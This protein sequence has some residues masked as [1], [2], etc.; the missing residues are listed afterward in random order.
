ME[1]L[2]GLCEFHVNLVNSASLRD[3]LFFET[4]KGAKC[5]ENGSA[6]ALLFRVFSRIS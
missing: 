3:G 4:T 6:A 2:S 5:R 1:D